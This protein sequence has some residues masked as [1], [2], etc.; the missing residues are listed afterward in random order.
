MISILHSMLLT[1]RDCCRGRA[2]LQAEILALRHQLLVLQR[3][4]RQRLRLNAADRLFWV[5]LLRLWK[6]WRSALL[7][8]KPETVLAWHRKG[9]RLYWSWKSRRDGG[10]PAVSREVR[11]L[12]RRMSLANRGGAPR[13]HGELLKLGIEVSQATVAKYMVRTRKPPSQTWRTFLENHAKGLVSTDFFVVP[14]I[15]F[16]LLFVFVVLSHHRRRPV[17]FAVTPNPTAEWT[18]HQLIEAFP[19][20]SVPRY[21]LRDRDGTYG[22]MFRETARWMGIREVLT[23]PQSP[24]QNPY[25]ERLIG[26]I[27][28]ECLDH[29]IVLDETGLRRVLKEYFEYY[30]QAS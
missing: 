23:A 2:A 22:D 25:I 24:W 19:W 4:N 27:R 26:S 7:I 28:R 18:A 21:L 29:I 17:H 20:D 10:R 9:F 6:E 8:V 16:R 1:L 15:T 3:S 13:I 14:T 11:D 12:I 30:K 5:W